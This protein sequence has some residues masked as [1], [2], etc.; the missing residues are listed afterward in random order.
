MLNREPV[1]SQAEEVHTEKPGE[2]RGERPSAMKTGT[3]IESN[4]PPRRHAATIPIAI[5]RTNERMN[6]TPTRKI[7]YGSTR[8]ITSDTGAG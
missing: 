7:E 6:A 8:P 3:T 5:P 1:Q 4:E 2:E